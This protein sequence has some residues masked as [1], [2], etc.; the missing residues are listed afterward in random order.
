MTDI[1]EDWVLDKANV[2]SGWEA[3]AEL[4]AITYASDA[5]YRALCDM[6]AKHEQKPVDR[7]LLCAREAI[8]QSHNHERSYPSNI[9]RWQW[10]AV[11]AIHLYEEGFGK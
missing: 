7:K 6:I 10:I 8:T 2:L 5:T 3:D 9:C 1:P 4:G 11:R